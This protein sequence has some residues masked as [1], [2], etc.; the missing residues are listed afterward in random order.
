MVPV[1]GGGLFFL[2]AF[3]TGFLAAFLTAFLAA[4]LTGFFV[5]MRDSPLV[6][7]ISPSGLPGHLKPIAIPIVI[8]HA[9]G[10]ECAAPLGDVARR[11]QS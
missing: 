6:L 1:G 10:V 9:A 8:P 5:G 2:A 4:F 3:F 7:A 11:Q